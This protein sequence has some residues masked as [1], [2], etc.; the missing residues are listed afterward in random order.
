MTNEENTTLM[1]DMILVG[2][3]CDFFGTGGKVDKPE[4]EFLLENKNPPYKIRGFID[5]P[6]LYKKNKQIKIRR[7]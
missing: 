5:K 2:L 7:L 6:I 3:R 4:H 1:N